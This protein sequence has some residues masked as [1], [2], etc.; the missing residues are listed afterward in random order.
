M[1]LT[2]AGRA[3]SA[4]HG[5]VQFVARGQA[6]GEQ[7]RQQAA[8]P[9]RRRGTDDEGGTDA[10]G[11]P[12]EVEEL[13]N[14]LDRTCRRD[15]MATGRQQLGGV[16]AVGVGGGQHH[17]LCLLGPVDHAVRGEPKLPTHAGTDDTRADDGDIEA[18]QW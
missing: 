5:D 15:H 6:S 11:E 7:P 8:E 3:G 12:V 9:W 16:V 2:R 17:D 18:G 10:L 4:V 1:M 13:T 14:V